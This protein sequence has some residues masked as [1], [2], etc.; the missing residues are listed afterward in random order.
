MPNGLPHQTFH[1]YSPTTFQ[2]IL[3]KDGESIQTTE[4]TDSNR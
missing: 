1:K 3:V 4:Q 2:K